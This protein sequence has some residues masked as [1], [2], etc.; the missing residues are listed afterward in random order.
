MRINNVI[1][2][3]IVTEKSLRNP[4][5]YAFMVNMQASKGAVVNEVERTYGVDVMDV[6]TMIVRGKKRRIAKTSRFGNS[7]NWKKA[8]VKLKEGQTIDLFAEK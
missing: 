6:H 5:E 1:K 3:P 7:G 2:K 4:G 8:I